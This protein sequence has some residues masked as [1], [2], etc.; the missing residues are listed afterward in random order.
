MR[1]A[2]FPGGARRAGVVGLALV[3]VLG[4][5]ACGSES[6]VGN[7]DAPAL[8]RQDGAITTSYLPTSF[9]REQI[10]MTLSYTCASGKLASYR[11]EKAPA[12]KIA[13]TATC[14]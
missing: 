4:L 1:L 2:V 6:V 7:P 10:M 14:S 12:G 8:T 11:E 5:G 9:S 13:V 3:S